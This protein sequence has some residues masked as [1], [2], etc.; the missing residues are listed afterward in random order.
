MRMIS[1]FSEFI[2]AAQTLPS[3][4]VFHNGQLELLLSHDQIFRLQR[5]LAFNVSPTGRPETFIVPPPDTSP[6]PLTAHLVASWRL[7]PRLVSITERAL[8]SG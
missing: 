1:S 6:G 2:R 4:V 7:Y 5:E 8:A 3:S